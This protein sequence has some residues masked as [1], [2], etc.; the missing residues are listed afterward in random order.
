MLDPE[1]V[2]AK[3]DMVAQLPK[4][5]FVMI[6]IGVNDFAKMT[7]E[8]YAA[9]RARVEE[10]VE[11]VNRNAENYDVAEVD[12]V[13]QAREQSDQLEA[14]IFDWSDVILNLRALADDVDRLRSQVTHWKEMF[15]THDRCLVMHLQQEQRKDEEIQFLRAALKEANAHALMAIPRGFARG[16]ESEQQYAYRVPFGDDTVEFTD[17]DECEYP[18]NCPN[19]AK[20]LRESA[21]PVREG[22]KP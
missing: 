11:T 20:F 5:K 9:N 13:E 7:D 1:Q 18:Y 4:E 17:R 15:D 6:E 21:E 16:Y 19:L 14:D 10:L 3:R 8:E 12:L 22:E 2:A